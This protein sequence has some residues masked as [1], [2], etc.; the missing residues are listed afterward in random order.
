MTS[1]PA[2][3]DSMAC[4]ARAFRR[5]SSGS[6]SA[7]IRSAGSESCRKRRRSETSSTPGMSA[8]SR[9][10]R[11]AIRTSA[12]T[13]SSAASILSSPTGPDYR[14]W[15]E[16]KRRFPDDIARKIVTGPSIEKSIAPLRSFV[17]EPMRYGRL[18]RRRRRPYRPTDR[19]ERLEP[20]G[21]RRLLSP[22]RPRRA[23]R[24]GRR[25]LSRKLFGHGA[26]TSLG[27]RA[28]FL[29]ADQAIA[30][31]SRRRRVRDQNQSERIRSYP[32]IEACRGDGRR[33]ICRVAIRGLSGLSEAR[34]TS[35]HGAE[36]NSPYW[37]LFL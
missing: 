22:A 7:P 35:L 19:G 13:T 5:R 10:P 37:S 26:E 2:A 32:P 30:R 1:S 3:T 11:C 23:F 33:T 14:F 29:V 28:I 36:V 4:L 31:L 9:S 27:G 20:G 8:A 17:A 6:S 15:E 16:L 21:L 18:L 24:Q 34:E 25:P 12:A